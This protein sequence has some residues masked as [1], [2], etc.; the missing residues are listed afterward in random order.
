MIHIHE[1][2]RTSIIPTLII[3]NKKLRIVFPRRYMTLFIINDDFNLSFAQIA[4]IQAQA[5]YGI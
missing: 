4:F 5:F 1:Y 3:R 2:N